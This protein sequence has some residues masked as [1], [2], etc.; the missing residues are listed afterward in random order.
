MYGS[1][2]HP[3]LCHIQVGKRQQEE[4]KFGPPFNFVRVGPRNHCPTLS[5]QPV[6]NRITRTNA[7]VSSPES[8]IGCGCAS[9]WAPWKEQGL[10]VTVTETASGPHRHSCKSCHL[11]IGCSGCCCLPIPRQNVLRCRMMQATVQLCC[12]QIQR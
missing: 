12:A 6:N 2:L 5:W 4:L 7:S 8:P 3:Q 10:T 11:K 9:I 1:S